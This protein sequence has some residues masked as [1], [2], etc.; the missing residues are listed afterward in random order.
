M[1]HCGLVEHR[2]IPLS[3]IPSTVLSVP[4]S[5]TCSLTSWSFVRSL[6]FSLVFG[7][8]NHLTDA[9]VQHDSLPIYYR[10]APPPTIHGC[11]RYT[12][13]HIDIIRGIDFK[14]CNPTGSHSQD[15]QS[16]QCG[17]VQAPLRPG[18]YVS[19]PTLVPIITNID[20][21]THKPTQCGA[22]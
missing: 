9:L 2:F 14:N 16:T 5:P 21:H 1:G 13:D 12:C 3:L 20:S 8:H 6:L 11:G 10:C 4:R 22:V 17:N 15:V 19:L 7:G 18:T